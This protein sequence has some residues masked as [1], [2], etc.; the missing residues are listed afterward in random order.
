MRVFVPEDPKHDSY[1]VIL[2]EL[3]VNPGQSVTN[4]ASEIAA[5]VM[6][7]FALPTRPRP[8]FIEHYED[9][10][11]GTPED[12]HTF[13]LL[14]FSGYDVREAFGADGWHER[15]GEPSWKALDR[16]SAELLVGRPLS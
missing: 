6:K 1:V 2:T 4:A 8:V 14:T 13:D 11:R 5:A 16:N 7:D 12:S 10:S 3:R 15:L 9:G